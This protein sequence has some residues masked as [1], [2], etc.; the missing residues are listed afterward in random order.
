MALDPSLN[1]K[2]IDVGRQVFGDLG[3]TDPSLLDPR[4]LNSLLMR[5]SMG[6][7]EFKVNLFRL[8]DVLPT[9]T[10]N[11]AIAE[12]V[13]E[14]LI[15]PANKMH[16][17]L[18]WFISL[19]EQPLLANV[20]ALMVK[21]GVKQMA[22]MF[23][24]GDSPT[25]ALTVLRR[26]RGERYSFTV[27]LLGEFCVCE[28][29]ANEYLNRYLDAI[30][31]FGG[32]IP[33]WKEGRPI[34]EGHP[35][36]ISPVCI[37]V[38]LSALYSQTN[39]LNFER[40]VS[41]LSERLAEIARRVKRYGA[42][43]YVD[44]EDSGN[45]SI[46]YEAFK[47]VFGSAEFIDLPYPGIVIQA[48]AKHSEA[49]VDEMLAFARQR[50]SPIAIRL[51][52]GAY[53]DFERVVS[54]QNDW[55]FPLWSKKQS[56]D[57][58]YEH[59]SRKLLDNHTLCLPAFGSHN[60]RSLSHACCYAESIGLSKSDFEVQVLYGMAEPIARAYMKRGYLVRMYVPLGELLPGMGYLVRRLLE[61]TSN[62]SF[63]RHTFFD[64]DEVSTLLR[65]P[66]LQPEDG[67]LISLSSPQSSIDEASLTPERA[68]ELP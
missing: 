18:G 52:K 13:R 56:S 66:H 25:A 49:R 6:Q 65:E 39:A 3:D 30:E 60:I 58:H 12:H 45:N 41:V 33:S 31:T 5:W 2:I 1:E 61:N 26:L 27:D 28:K 63:L 11:Q 7:P 47:R 15:P 68:N 22:S 16:P 64:E 62:E 20:A 53:W 43:M 37:S 51:V 17:S 23:I 9:L 55:E 67:A 57:A 42:L 4:Y 38:K 21:Q 32:T 10:S 50:G 19:C 29:E 36:E 14:Y 8:V 54:S 35:G 24:A 44:A 48:Y 34:I 59:L 40:S 46:I